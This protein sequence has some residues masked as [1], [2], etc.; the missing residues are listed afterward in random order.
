MSLEDALS[1]LTLTTTLHPGVVAICAGAIG[2]CV[3]SFLNV[4]IHR[5]PK[6]QSV[7][8]PSSHCACGKPIPFWL[9]LPLLGW[10]LL[11]G[12]AACC[13]TRISVRYPVIELLT[14]LAFAFAI[15]YLPTAKALVGW[16]FLSLLILLSACDLEEML[17]PDAPNFT[18][19]GLGIVFSI[20][21]PSLHGEKSDIVELTQRLNA[22]G[23]SLLGI[24]V[25]TAT[26]WW[27]RTLA[28]AVMGQEAMGEAD[29]ILCAGVGA[30]CG[31]QGA[32][33]CLFGGAVIGVIL[34]LPSLLKLFGPQKV[35]ESVPFVPSMAI[36][37]TLWFFKGPALVSAWFEWVS[38]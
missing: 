20:L 34:K 30:F 9:N 25:G 6:G 36:A 28:T 38:Y 13:G 19:V 16:V 8:T 18:L 10:V 12:K 33:F 5:L 29:I 22:I 35:S 11:R 1:I 27:I 4:C 24:A 21:V 2:A 26:V 23:H 3:G 17:V 14:A 37:A 31:W 15:L 7:V 32:L